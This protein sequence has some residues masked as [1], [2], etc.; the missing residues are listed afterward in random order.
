M[1]F[2][3]I[4][5]TMYFLQSIS[6]KLNGIRCFSYSSGGMMSSW[7]PGWIECQLKIFSDMPGYDLFLRQELDVTTQFSFTF[8][9]LVLVRK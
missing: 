1:R 6:F 4:T 7:L 8:K 2:F 5:I 9:N 3:D